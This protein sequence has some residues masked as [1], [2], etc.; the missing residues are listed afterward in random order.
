MI[1]SDILRSR[2][3]F[4]QDKP[5]EEKSNI[6]T[7]IKAKEIRLINQDGENKGIVRTDEAL[8]MAREAKLD[9][10]EMSNSNPPVC[11]I[12]NHGK[13]LYNKAKKAKE[14]KHSKQNDKEV[15]LRPS[16][17]IHDLKIKAKQTRKFIEEGRKVNIN[18]KLKG[19]EKFNVDVI[20]NVID[21]FYE[22][23]N[24]IATL[25]NKGGSY[26]LIPQKI[27]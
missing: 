13:Y 24:D 23:V 10:V 17:D 4:F 26:I 3:R 8:R 1:R 6:N 22:L 20:K 18:V 25:E 11:K 2:K 9:L 21:K 12:M 14:N 7:N 27:K 19:R 16:T 15:R 5:T